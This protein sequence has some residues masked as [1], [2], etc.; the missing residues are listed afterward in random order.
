MLGK[1]GCVVGYACTVLLA[2][3]GDQYVSDS[4]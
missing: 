2:I 4:L 1:N 3:A